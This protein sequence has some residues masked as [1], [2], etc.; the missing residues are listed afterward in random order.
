MADEDEEISSVTISSRKKRAGSTSSGRSGAGDTGNVSGG[1]APAHAARRVQTTPLFGVAAPP[2]PGD[3]TDAADDLAEVVVSSTVALPSGEQLLLG[4]PRGLD[5]FGR[6]LTP[7]FGRGTAPYLPGIDRPPSLG[8]PIPGFVAEPLPEVTVEAQKPKNPAAPPPRALTPGAFGAFLGGLAGWAFWFLT[9]PRVANE[10]E[11]SRVDAALRQRTAELIA[12]LQPI[13]PSVGRLVEPLPEVTVRSRKL[14][15]AAANRATR[16]V[17][18]DVEPRLSPGRVG[19]QPSPNSFTYPAA[20]RTKSSFPIT[21]EVIFGAR[22][23]SLVDPLT[24]P[25]L[26][27]RPVVR[28]RPTPVV[29]RTPGGGVGSGVPLA[30]I[31]GVGLVIPLP[32]TSPSPGTLTQFQPGRVNDCTCTKTA[33]KRKKRSPRAECWKGTYVETA[34]GL[35]KTRREKVPC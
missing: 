33:Q 27:P 34:L 23:R 18:T 35:L 10:G 26:R 22:P 16:G 19:F 17:R 6:A 11:R 8:Q 4:N 28:A 13:V 5:A 21:S 9:V 14:S 15:G 24:D 3:A 32:G 2:P 29:P 30:P 7:P 12:G 25:R 31:P 20:Q 1:R